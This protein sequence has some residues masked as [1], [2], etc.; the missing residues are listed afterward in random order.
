MTIFESFGVLGLDLRPASC[1]T[2]ILLC[3]LSLRI[4]WRV[5]IEHDLLPG[6]REERSS[7]GRW[8]A[9]FKKEKAPSRWFVKKGV[10]QIFWWSLE[11]LAYLGGAHS[12]LPRILVAIPFSTSSGATDMES[13]SGSSAWEHSSS[14]TIH[15]NSEACNEWKQKSANNITMAKIKSR[16]CRG[17]LTLS[18]SFSY[19]KTLIKK[20]SAFKRH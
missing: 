9:A 17:L 14:E 18:F 6:K 20:L 8:F 10:C 7:H 3:D 5:D 13:G 1:A 2:I 19:I 15:S 4:F 16:Q 11:D 12:R